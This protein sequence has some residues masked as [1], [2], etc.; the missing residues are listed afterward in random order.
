MI[1]RVE[2]DSL[3]EQVNRFIVVLRREGLVPLIFQSSGLQVMLSAARKD[4]TQSP[5]VRPT[6]SKKTD[7]ISSKS[8]GYGRQVVQNFICNIEPL[9]S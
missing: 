2:R 1:L 5:Y 7:S 3:C 4:D 8:M 9:L 6:F